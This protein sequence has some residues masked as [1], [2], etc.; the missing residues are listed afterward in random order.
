MARVS[1][2]TADG[3]SVANFTQL[4]SAWGSISVGSGVFSCSSSNTANEG[5]AV[6]SGAGSFSD[7]Q[8]AE[9][10][11]GGLSFL[12]G[13][14]AIGVICRASTDTGAG[15]D[16][17]FA[18]VAADSGGPNY[19]T[20]L[21]KVVNGTRTVIHSAANAWANGDKISL[22][23]DGTTLRV[24]KNVTALGGSFTQTDTALT[25]GK[26]G[27]IANGSSPTGDDWV[28]GTLS[29]A[30]G[31]VQV[32]AIGLVGTLGISGDIA[33]EAVIPIEPVAPIALVGTLSIAGDLAFQVKAWRIPTNAPTGTEVHVTILNGSGNTYTE[34]TQGRT[35]VNA[36]GNI[37]FPA[38]G[39]VGMKLL[40]FVH[41]Y[42]DD[43]ETT[44]IYGGP[45]IATIVDVG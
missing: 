15:R 29:S 22:E 1:V 5:A 24:H 33:V 27:I 21:G 39:A 13:D 3:T 43:T 31:I 25:T 10:T 2:A 12:S 34:V 32:G 11:I 30:F 37:Y 18:Y 4:N 20:V 35:T 19:T 45:C 38:Q 26:P 7:D 40:A 23:V 17:Y 42:D 44:S 14:F 28:S 8:Y 6:W 16:F 36:D 41:N 9:I